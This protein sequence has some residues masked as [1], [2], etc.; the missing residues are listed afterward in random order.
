MEWTIC[1]TM[2]AYTVVIFVLK[3]VIK[4]RKEIDRN[5]S[6]INGPVDW[7]SVNRNAFSR[8][9]YK[10]DWKNEGF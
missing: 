9:T 1:I 7:E 6:I 10:V 4:F 5:Y 8:N 2:L 3:E